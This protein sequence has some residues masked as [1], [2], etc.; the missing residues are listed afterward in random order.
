MVEK[1]T[2]K[3]LI[4]ISCAV[5]GVNALIDGF[6]WFTSGFHVPSLAISILILG[7]SVILL[8]YDKL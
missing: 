6:L 1:K 4:K 7:Y 3:R 8:A 2:I 5:Q